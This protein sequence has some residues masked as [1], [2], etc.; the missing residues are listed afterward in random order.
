[1]AILGKVATY[2]EDTVK[3]LKKVKGAMTYPAVVIG[4]AILLVN[5]LLI[6]VIPVFAEMFSSFDQELPKPTQILISTSEF[7]QS[8]ILYIIG[9]LVAVWHAVKRIV[10]TP[11]GRIA[12]DKL[13]YKLPVIGNLIQKVG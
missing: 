10:R 2:F 11:N 7:L 8:N 9:G 1:G 5:V 6:F 3:L 4:I 13:L 12:R